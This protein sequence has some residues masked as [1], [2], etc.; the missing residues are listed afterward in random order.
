MDR[1]DK[2]EQRLDELHNEHTALVSKVDL[3]ER[4]I[5]GNGTPGIKQ[6]LEKMNEKLDTFIKWKSNLDQT[7]Q[8]W[9]M[10]GPARQQSCNYLRDKED[11]TLK[12]GATAKK[13][14][15]WALIITL[16]IATIPSGIV[17]WRV[18]IATEKSSGD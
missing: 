7:L 11:E 8:E 15:L 5:M 4:D 14:A 18:L 10:N 9:W 3:I 17:A 1:L 13:I 6:Y 12:R 16:F 2:I